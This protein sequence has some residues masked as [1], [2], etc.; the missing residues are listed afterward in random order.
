MY[1][2]IASNF[3][4]CIQ[5]FERTLSTTELQENNSSL[6]CSVGAN[7]LVQAFHIS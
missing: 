6:F 5:P 7:Q 3:G 2:F 4:L 1:L